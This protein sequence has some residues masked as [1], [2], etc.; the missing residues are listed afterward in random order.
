MTMRTFVDSA[1][2]EW[3]VFDVVPRRDERRNYD[4]RTARSSGPSEGERREQDRRFT[5][6]G[7][8][9]LIG[10]YDAWLCFE[11]GAE[12]RRL[13]PIPEKW[14]RFTDQELEQYREAARPV[15]LR[16]QSAAVNP[17]R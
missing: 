9:R 13:S 12:R 6:G 15:R 3:Q 8:S 5:V 2:R 17:R 7:R 11:R 1:G 16:T 4:R 14:E 10:L